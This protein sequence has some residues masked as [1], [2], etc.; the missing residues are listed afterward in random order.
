M[1]VKLKKCKGTGQATNNGC[2][3]EVRKRTYGLCDSCYY[4]WLINTEP[5]RAKLEKA[6][7]KAKRIEKKKRDVHRKEQ[8]ENLKTHKDWLKDLEKVF[9]AY[10]RKRDEGQPCISCGKPYGTFTNSAGHYFPG[11]SNPSIRFDEDNVHLQCWF[12]CNK[13]RHGNQAE[14]LPNL[15]KKIGQKRFDELCERRNESKKLSIPEIKVLI[16]H[17][18]EK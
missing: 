13:N 3:K 15:I 6:T 5:G 1:E 7:L 2:G 4:D 12:D 9:N 11:G 14:Y 8:K 16:E 18:K 10:I 17:Y